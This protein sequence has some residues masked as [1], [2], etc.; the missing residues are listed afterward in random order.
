MSPKHKKNRNGYSRI[1]GYY[2]SLI[3]AFCRNF[4]VLGQPN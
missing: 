4:I 3:L 1:F 2:P